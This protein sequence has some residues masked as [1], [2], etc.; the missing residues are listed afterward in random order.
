MPWFVGHHL[1]KHTEAYFSTPK[2]GFS[3]A[4]RRC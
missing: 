2:D 4:E 3:E 1:Q